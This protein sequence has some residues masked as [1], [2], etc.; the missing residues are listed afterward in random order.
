M[1]AAIVHRGPD[2]HGVW[3]D[4]GTGIG[5]AHRRLAILDLSAAGHQPMHSPCGRYVL[6]F[7]GEIYNHLD[8]RRRL[9][10]EGWRGHSDTETLLAGFDAWGI[11]TTLTRAVGM[12]AVAVWDRTRRTLT[13]ARDRLGEKPLYY[14]RQ[15]DCFLFGSELKAL[16]AHPAFTAEVDRTALDLF[17][18]RGYV[19]APHS[20]YSG[21]RKLPPGM[22]LTLGGGYQGEPRP[23][24]TVAA[25]RQAGVDD[26]LPL[27]AEVCLDRLETLLREAIAGQMVADVPL[28]AFL[29]GGIDSSLVVALMQSVSAQPVRTF[30]IGFTEQGYDEAGH[31]R[32]V[33][34]HLGTQHSELYVSPQEAMAVIPRLPAIYDEPFADASQIPTLLVSEMARRQVTVCLSGDGGDELFAGYTRYFWT[35]AV[36][37][38]SAVLPAPLRIFVG[39]RLA[40]VSPAVL[41][42]AFALLSP[43]LP[44]H[45]RFARAGDKLRKLAD[46]LAARCVEAACR[47]A[48]G[49]WKNEPD[50]V[51]GLPVCEV[52]TVPDTPLADIENHMMAFDQTGYLPDDILAKVDRAAMAVSLETRIPLL[53][54]RVVE[55]A[56]KL[57]LALKVRDGR[58]KWLLRQLLYRHVP[59]ALIDRPK[60]GFSVPIDDW[61]RGPLRDWAEALLDP[62]RLADE[63]WLAPVPV[64]RMWREHLDGRRNAAG[65]MWNVLT[66]QAWLEHARGDGR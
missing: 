10:G 40:R 61:L 57:P 28:G 33:A 8:L 44:A 4:A 1:A 31:A 19:P 43:V 58:G 37:R 36:L 59:Q 13:L 42:R 41:E 65:E 15:G 26:P 6:V 30:S 18:R 55:Y 63:G 38:R 11:E 27:N 32:A 16:R 22:L 35:A 48:N 49:F 34:A 39:R 17:L 60:M 5:L 64:R 54:H 21:I 50:L 24:W 46:I 9:G 45:W 56:W 52:E 29:S 53:D 20:I 62:D 47:N 51:T 3:H 66:F 14:G 23:Y 7:N 25:A 12:F 2:G